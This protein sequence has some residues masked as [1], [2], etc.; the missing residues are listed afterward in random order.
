MFLFRSLN[1]LKNKKSIFFNNLNNLYKYIFT[2]DYNL[3]K[4]HRWCVKTS[5]I[6]KKSCNWEKKNEN[7]NIDNSF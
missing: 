6:Y 2:N 3:P 5:N 1:I 4:L 7:A